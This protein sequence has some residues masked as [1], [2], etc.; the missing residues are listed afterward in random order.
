MEKQLGSLELERKSL[1]D[2]KQGLTKEKQLAQAEW[3]EK[4][5]QQVSDVRA[6]KY[7]ND[8]LETEVNILKTDFDQG[9][10]RITE[11]EQERGHLLGQLQQ[12]ERNQIDSAT[13]GDEYKSVLRDMGVLEQEYKKDQASAKGRIEDLDKTISELRDDI[14]KYRELQS[15]LEEKHHELEVELSTSADHRKKFDDGE[16]EIAKLKR[17]LNQTQVE[18]DKHKSKKGV[19]STDVAAGEMQKELTLLKDELFDLQQ[20]HR[21][22]EE[23][24]NSITHELESTKQR[25]STEGRSAHEQAEKLKELARHKVKTDKELESQKTELVLAKSNVADTESQLKAAQRLMRESDIKIQQINN[26]LKIAQNA[27]AQTTLFKEKLEA[28][29]RET[30]D[31]LKHY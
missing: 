13:Q 15:I 25:V 29:K 20:R 8:Q 10:K 14:R 21:G 17:Q 3:A 23:E 19:A 5:E 18:L 22:L 2:A 24:K 30:K 9:K 4:Y 28:I 12:S 11:L 1:D 26:E 6:A 31:Q 27:S 16:K 7:R